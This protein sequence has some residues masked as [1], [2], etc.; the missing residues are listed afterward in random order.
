MNYY[1]SVLFSPE[2]KKSSLRRSLPVKALVLSPAAGVET[3]YHTHTKQELSYREDL[4]P[5]SSEITFLNIL[6]SRGD[7]LQA[8][9]IYSS[10]IA[11]RI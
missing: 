5:Y 10:S 7:P 1:G 3:P 6:S 11:R 9:N 8:D 2:I 4:N